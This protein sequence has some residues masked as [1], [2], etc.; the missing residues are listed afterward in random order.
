MV[1]G[2]G[3]LL[4]LGGVAYSATDPHEHLERS[5]RNEGG[6]RP[7]YEERRRFD[8]RQQQESERKY[9]PKHG[10]QGVPSDGVTPE[11]PVPR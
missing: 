7:D 8:E 9:E 4:C 5:E 11:K 6:P 3:G 1:L 2:I 10:Q